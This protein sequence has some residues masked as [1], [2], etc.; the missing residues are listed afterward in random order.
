M[1]TN[2]R[3]TG[4]GGSVVARQLGI[5]INNGVASQTFTITGNQVTACSGAGIYIFTSDTGIVAHNICR[6]NVTNAAN[7]GS[8]ADIYFNLNGGQLDKI[9]CGPNIYGSFSPNQTATDAQASQTMVVGGLKKIASQ[10]I[11]TVQGA[12]AHGLPY[13]PNKVII[14]MTSSGTVWESQAAD[15][16]N[17]YLTASAASRTCDVYVA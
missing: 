9:V 17:V 16:T 5:F 10:T 15:G 7:A 12:V 6:G 4:A 3:I 1:Y 8:D 2:N 11:G 13:T 14:K